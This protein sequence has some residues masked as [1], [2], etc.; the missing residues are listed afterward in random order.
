[1]TVNGHLRFDPGSLLK[2][3]IMLTMLKMAEE[4]PKVFSTPWKL[5]DV[6]PLPQPAFPPS[7][8]IAI[9]QPYT[10]PQLIEYSIQRSDNLAN[11]LMIQHMDF[12]QFRRM[13]IEVGLPDMANGDQSY[14]LSTP[15][16]AMFFKAIYNTTFL[17]PRTSDFA[18][19][20]L[21]NCEFKDGLRAGIPKEVEVA[22]KF[23]ES[24]PDEL[25]QF[26]EAGMVYAGDTPYL[27][28]VMTRGKDIKALPG[29]VAGISS[30]VYKS[31]TGKPV[32]I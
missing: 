7:K 13:L 1:M 3:P 22:H 27:I 29:F 28:V 5:T 18:M 26:H 17:S 2:V 21:V 20:Q 4:D 32:A 9:G 15:D 6:P 8:A 10:L 16:Y 25:R 24:G 31:M 30:I 19:H 12:A 23:G 11:T 14:P